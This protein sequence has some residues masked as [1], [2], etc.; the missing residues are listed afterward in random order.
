MRVHHRLVQTAILF[1]GRR[2]RGMT[3][4][5]RALLVSE[6]RVVLVRHTYAPGWYLPG[7]GV[8]RGESAA[9]AL[10]REVREE[11]GARLTA[12]PRLFGLYRNAA[13]DPRDHVA[14]YVCEAFEAIPDA[15]R[16][17]GEIAEC[18]AFPVDALPPD[19]T[20]AT[21]ARLREYLIGAAPS[22]DW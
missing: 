18:D 19:V 12:G 6:G 2:S 13:A 5:V 14:L 10:E 4:G 15:S 3:L 21:V 1:Y 20:R 9:E 17:R 7:G 22:T 16:P 8:E 11:A